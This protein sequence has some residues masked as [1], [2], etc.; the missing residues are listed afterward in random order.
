MGANRV[1]GL[2]VAVVVAVVTVVFAAPPVDGSSRSSG[3][4]RWLTAAPNDPDYAGI[5]A[6]YLV[7]GGGGYWLAGSD[8]GIFAFDAPY[9]GSLG[10][11]KL[12]APV[13]GMAGCGDGY[14][15]V[16]SDGGVFDFSGCPFAGSLAGKPDTT[17]VVG[18]SVPSPL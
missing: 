13:R 5:Q 9:R 7:A 4:F 8:G 16:A 6:P 18:L 12:D 2:R 15:L 1:H 3:P 10:S 11:T 17:P 14:L